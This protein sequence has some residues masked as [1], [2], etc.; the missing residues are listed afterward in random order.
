MGPRGGQPQAPVG[1][2][3][4]TA[5][6]VD[7]L[8]EARRAASSKQVMQTT[9][10]A[11]ALEGSAGRTAVEGVDEK[12]LIRQAQAG[13]RVAFDELVR[14]YDRDVLRLTLNLVRRPEDARDLYQEAFLKVFRNLPR[15]RFECSFY[16]WLYRIVTNVCLDHLRRRNSR[17]EHQAPEPAGADAEGASADFFDRQ[18]ER[19]ARTDPERY[20]LGREIRQKI[21]AAMNELS[22]RERMVFELKHYHGLKLRAIGEMM[23]TSEETVKNA[24]FRGTRKLRARLEG[25]L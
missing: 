3:L 11:V 13:S 8:P 24:L 18:P 1:A 17:P 9:G 4:G 21:A 25:L 19:R 6:P 14:R 23:G 10:M 16:T 2:A 22:A 12:A 15:F 20:L 7:G 5:L